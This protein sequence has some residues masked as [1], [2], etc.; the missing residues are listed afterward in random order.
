MQMVLNSNAP[1]LRCMSILVL[2][3]LVTFADTQTAPVVSSQSHNATNGAIVSGLVAMSSLDPLDGS[4]YTLNVIESGKYVTIQLFRTDGKQKINARLVPVGTDSDYR[5]VDVRAVPPVSLRL[6]AKPGCT[7]AFA[8]AMLSFG[9][10]ARTYSGVRL[11][12]ARLDDGNYSIRILSAPFR[13]MD[14]GV[15]VIKPDGTIVSFERGY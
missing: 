13:P 14:G 11:K 6:D 15:Y 4:E 10:D 5:L 8:L 7:K 3:W 2:A 9:K 12:G 1:A